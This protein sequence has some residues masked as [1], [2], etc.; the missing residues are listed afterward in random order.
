MSPSKPAEPSLPGPP[1]E[2]THALAFDV[3]EPGRYQRVGLLGQGGMGRVFLARDLRLERDV[4]LK[5]VLREGPDTAA[6]L[7]REAL[8]TAQL[9]HPGIVPVYDAGRTAGG[10]LFYTMRLVRGRRLSDL[11]READGVDARLRLVPHVRDVARALAFAHERQVVHRDVKPDNVLIGSLG[12]TQLSDWGLARR[13]DAAQPDPAATPTSLADAELTRVGDGLVGTTR[14]AAPE[15]ARGSPASLRSDVYSLGALLLEVVTGRPPWEGIDNDGVVARLSAG[16]AAPVELPAQTPPALRT[17]IARALAPRPDDR[18]AS[19]AE[20]AADLSALLDGRLVA[21]HTYSARELLS[22]FVRTWRVPLIAAGSVLA[23]ALVALTAAGGVA[24]AQ[25]DRALEAER[26][27]EARAAELL[28]QRA[29]ELDVTG[30]FAEMEY[31]AVQAAALQP[32]S[33][34]ALGALMAARAPQAPKLKSIDAA[35]P[36]R[37]AWGVQGGT[38]CLDASVALL[39]EA[40]VKWR[41]P[42]AAS[43][44]AVD[45][46]GREALLLVGGQAWR[47][48]V[49]TGELASLGPAPRY[50]V[51][52]GL[53][54]ALGA[55]VFNPGLLRLTWLGLTRELTPCARG[56]ELLGA[57]PHRGALELLCSDGE[58]RRVTPWQLMSAPVGPGWPQLADVA[59]VE[60]V[61][62]GPAALLAGATTYAFDGTASRIVGTVRGTVV[63]VSL[64]TGEV[65]LVA[66]RAQLGPLRQVLP[67]REGLLVVGERGG[68]ELLDARDGLPKASLPEW[69]RG[70]AWRENEDVVLHGQRRA[71]WT[72]AGAAAGRWSAPV[73]LAGA[74]FSGDGASALLAGADGFVA[75]WHATESHV[76]VRPLGLSQVVK[77]VALSD[78]ERGLVGAVGLPGVLVLEGERAS[79]VGAVPAMR[80]VGWLAPG[81]G[82]AVGY[83]LGPYFLDGARMDDSV[84]LARPW[85]DANATTSGDGL[86]LLDADGEVFVAT[87]GGATARPPQPGA[88]LVVASSITG[89]FYFA[90]GAEVHSTSG[91]RLS[92][93]E[94]FVTALSLSPDARWLAVG[95]SQGSLLIA[96]AATLQLR[97]RAPL[98]RD[99][100]SGIAFSKRG[101]LVTVGWDRQARLWSLAPLLEVPTPAEVAAKWGFP[102]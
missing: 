70:A 15:L 53:D 17:L 6:R 57:L 33:P 13:V 5:E 61:R 98:H 82:W 45:A 48:S 43:Q 2:Q 9:D 91:A 24:R 88:S 58:L 69:A 3:E 99:R 34:D 35:P 26:A 49:A 52:L 31:L 11:I 25:R 27:A 47:V 56:A 38:L 8:L 101:T 92:L 75:R 1:G 42:L 96:D 41:V 97:A 95:S 67:L 102:L 50:A 64:F 23:V 71:R 86:V 79:R 81:V 63:R 14:Y 18:A 21:A 93:A 87:R 94:G 83:E 89:P 100:V 65:Q 37:A 22:H 76:D 51:G 54:A 85:I 73:G 28:V 68:P 39:T 44:A 77:S 36:C 29:R 62:V 10:R 32:G 59:G 30:S 84:A 80:R 20:L 74:S 60:R 19:A 55:W 16:A 78:D 7:V 72:F 90:R 4:A 12:E 66:S 46:S 40:G